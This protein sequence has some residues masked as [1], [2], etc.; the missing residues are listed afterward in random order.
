VQI[1]RIEDPSDPRVADYRN[2]PDPELRRQRGLFVVEGRDIAARLLDS[3][4]FSARSVFL[5]E[6]ALADLGDRL[7]RADLR[8]FV[9]SAAIVRSIV[10]YRF[11]R[12]CLALG[13]RG[14][15]PAPSALIDPPGPRLLVAA[16]HVTN[17]DNVGG[18]F[19]N[20]LAFGVDAVLLSGRS[21]DPLY[22]K[23]I[24]VSI[25]G[26]LAVPFARLDDWPAA[27]RQIS[28]AGYTVIALTP[29]RTAMDIGR[30]AFDVRGLAR[31]ALL[32]GAE[33]HGLSGESRA[34]A[35]IQVRIPMA[36]GVDSLNVA[37]ATGI[38]LHRLASRAAD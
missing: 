38:A 32:V 6:A 13:E 26:S 4:R 24:R 1:E 10:G 20:A 36:S 30:L 25:G 23:S 17:P 3:A 8:V 21:A 18:I 37:T 11:H 29:H 31:V 28:A 9:A 14:P 22:R 34:C 33:D 12:G 19:R 2:L 5:T 15:D 7:A 27:L 16:E 35:D